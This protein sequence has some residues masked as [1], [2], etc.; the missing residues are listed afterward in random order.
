M[1][2]IDWKL[3]GF[4]ITILYVVFAVLFFAYQLGYLNGFEKGIYY[5]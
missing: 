5:E 3:I 4:V 1:N 2:K